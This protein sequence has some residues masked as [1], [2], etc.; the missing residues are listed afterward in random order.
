MV[1]QGVPER[2]LTAEEFEQAER[3]MEE[4]LVA[5][6]LPPHEGGRPKTGAGTPTEESGAAREKR[7]E[8][9]KEAN[10]TAM[11]E[12][13]WGHVQKMVQEVL[14]K[15]G[16]AEG[17]FRKHFE[18]VEEGDTPLAKATGEHT[19][20]EV[21][22]RL[23]MWWGGKLDVDLGGKEENQT[24]LN[25][26]AYTMGDQWNVKFALDRTDQEQWKEMTKLAK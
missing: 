1:M 26:F 20:D 18:E 11:K 13:E 12:V 10:I 17:I 23:I 3:M 7:G 5:T 19:E 15:R 6:T 9:E 4:D 2:Q 25:C 16:E 14:T 21:I 8:E 22:G 24:A